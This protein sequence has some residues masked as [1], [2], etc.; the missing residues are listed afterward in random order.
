VFSSSATFA[1]STAF[2]AS[3]CASLIHPFG[4]PFAH[5]ITFFVIC[6]SDTSGYLPKASLTTYPFN[7]VFIFDSV[8]P[9]G[10]ISRYNLPPS[11]GYMRSLRIRLCDLFGYQKDNPFCH[12]SRK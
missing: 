5:I 9:A 4:N 11:K 2:T 8:E 7:R 6:V 12:I 1:V 10:A 3:I